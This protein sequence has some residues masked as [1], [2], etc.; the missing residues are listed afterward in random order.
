MAITNIITAATS[1]PPIIGICDTKGLEILGD[2]SVVDISS[3]P[4]SM[5]I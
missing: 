4:A 3:C 1:E 2:T 5:K